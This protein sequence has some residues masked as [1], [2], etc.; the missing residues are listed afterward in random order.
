MITKSQYKNSQGD[1]VT[2]YQNKKG[3]S[4]T[5]TENDISI[6][7]PDGDLMGGMNDEFSA[8]KFLNDMDKS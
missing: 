7:K 8:I 3:Y 1:T 5:I 6:Y 4:V 2:L